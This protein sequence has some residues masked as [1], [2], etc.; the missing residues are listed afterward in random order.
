MKRLSLAVAASAVL[1]AL[2]A[3]AEAP[4]KTVTLKGEVVDTVCYLSKG[5]H[6]AAHKNCSKSC[7]HKGAPA[8]FLSQGKLY[9]LLAEHGNESVMQQVADKGGEEV[10]LTGKQADKDGLP[11]LFV[12]S[13]K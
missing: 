3:L 12:E 2:P 7:L 9:L 4:S 8:G 5:A 6:G 13:V 11:A 10:S 1:F